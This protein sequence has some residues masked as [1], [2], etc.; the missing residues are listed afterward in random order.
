MFQYVPNES[1]NQYAVAVL[2]RW[3]CS[4]SKCVVEQP[5]NRKERGHKHEKHNTS[6]HETVFKC[7]GMWSLEVISPVR[8]GA[9]CLHVSLPFAPVRTCV[10]ILLTTCLGGVWTVEQPLGSVLE[11]YNT[12]RRIVKSIY[13]TGG[14]FAVP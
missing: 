8:H 7:L 11:F 2:Q 14:P 6:Y 10:L 5:P 13:D 12:F 4:V 1:W 9:I 3:L